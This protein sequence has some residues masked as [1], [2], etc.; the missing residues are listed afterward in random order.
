MKI[1]ILFILMASKMSTSLKLTCKGFWEKNEIADDIIVDKDK[2]NRYFS[3]QMTQYIGQ[4][5]NRLS[6]ID[7]ENEK[8]KKDDNEDDDEEEKLEKLIINEAGIYIRKLKSLDND[9]NNEKNTNSLAELKMNKAQTVNKTNKIRNN[10]NNFHANRL[11]E[12]PNTNEQNNS[13]EDANQQNKSTSRYNIEILI[14]CIIDGEYMQQ[15]QS[16]K[17]ACNEKTEKF[18]HYVSLGNGNTDLFTF[19]L[20]KDIGHMEYKQEYKELNYISYKILTDSCEIV[21]TAGIKTL[22][23]FILI[24]LVLVQY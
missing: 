24:L 6:H 16:I 9:K 10:T 4:L 1:K 8:M 19:D 3:N 12:E 5:S 15:I 18:N 17:L 7:N 13:L 14:N 2:V 22:R 21:H 20:S 11:L 23:T